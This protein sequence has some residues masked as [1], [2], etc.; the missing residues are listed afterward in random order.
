VLH[1]AQDLQR[2][3]WRITV[4]APHAE[5]ARSREELDG[6]HVERFRY[7]WPARAQTVCYGGGALINLRRD[8]R[9][10]M[11]L[12]AL[13]GAEWAATAR[14]IGR[15]DLVNAHWILPQGFV[16]GTIPGRTPHVVTVHGGD[17]FGLQGKA[18]ARAKRW[19]LLRADAVTCNSSITERAV[20]ALAPEVVPAR[21]PMGAST[22]SPPDP[23]LTRRLREQYRRGTG[24]LLVFVGRIVEEK[25]F[26]EFLG[27]VAALERTF[28]DV[29]GLVVGDGQQ[30]SDAE[31]HSRD[32]DI[33]DRV[34]FAGWV[35]SG[36]VPSHMA[37]GDVFVAPSKRGPD[38]WVEAQGLSVVEAMLAGVPVV[39]SA[40]GGIVDTIDDGVT[41]LLVP[42]GDAEAIAASVRTL[43]GNDH[44][45][46]AIVEAA[47]QSARQRFSREASARAFDGLFRSLVERRQ[48]PPGHAP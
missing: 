35:D 12:P 17:I 10:L 37:A 6:V 25:G 46:R 11:K 20:N 1:L 47:S 19:S 26:E 4:L 33:A 32:L 29:T 5:H 16:A 42:E 15:A 18:L 13:V 41:G 9:N 23:Q 30:R 43:L 34:H 48:A 3:D 27:A 2:L 7:L 36:A 44:S 24:P 38:G 31:Q 39:A 28:P 8:R 40:S 21:I 22:S 45:R 14:R